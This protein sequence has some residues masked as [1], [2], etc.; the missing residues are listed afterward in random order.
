MKRRSIDDDKD[1]KN[2]ED[3]DNDN[4]EKDG[5]DNDTLLAAVQHA[6]GRSAGRRMW[7]AA[8][9]TS[10]KGELSSIGITS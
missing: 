3:D 1:S 8:G 9:D 6:D 4:N 2:Y 7:Q 10:G 5:D